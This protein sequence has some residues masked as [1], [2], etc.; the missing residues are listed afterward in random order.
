MREAI[1]QG[2]GFL[3]QARCKHDARPGAD[4]LLEQRAVAVQTGEHGL[5]RRRGLRRCRTHLPGADQPAGIHRVGQSRKGFRSFASDALL[6]RNDAARGEQ[7]LRFG[8]QNRIGRRPRIEP[9]QQAAHVKSRAARHDAAAAVSGCVQFSAHRVEIVGDAE[10]RV[11][12]CEVD[13]RVAMVLP[14]PGGWF[15]RADVHAAI[16]Q[17][18]IGRQHGQAQAVGEQVGYGRLACG[19][20][21]HEEERL[22]GSGRHATGVHSA[23]G[24]VRTRAAARSR[25]PSRNA[26][27]R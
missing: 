24:A 14:F 18:R 3:D 5:R 21:A 19:G 15:R 20:G 11:G 7:L 27:T 16:D 6:Q 9:L 2:R 26:V 8:A 4:A 23:G 10:R 22:A 25:R 17:H 13:S 1:S 12:V